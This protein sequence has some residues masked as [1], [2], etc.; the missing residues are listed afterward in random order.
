M[1]GEDCFHAFL[2][3]ISPCRLGKVEILDLHPFLLHKQIFILETLDL[4]LG[5]K[6]HL[7][8]ALTTVYL[9]YLSYAW[10]VVYYTDLW[11]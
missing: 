5:V 4:F 3:L 8:N 9:S 6:W 1:L 11:S 10:L 2:C 7:V